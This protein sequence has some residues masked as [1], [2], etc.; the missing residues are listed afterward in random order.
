MKIMP[1]NSPKGAIARLLR[2]PGVWEQCQ[3]WRKDGDH[4]PSEPLD[5]EDFFDGDPDAPINDIFDGF[6]WR[7]FPAFLERRWDPR[8]RQVD[9][10]AVAPGPV[11]RFVSLPCG[12]LVAINIDW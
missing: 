10:V 1:Y 6:G 7:Q 5:V 12:L 9:D 4:G 11:R 8:R 3:L 2:R